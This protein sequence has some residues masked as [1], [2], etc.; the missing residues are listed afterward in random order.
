M[1]FHHTRSIVSMIGYGDIV[2]RTEPGKIATL[3]Y[4][5]FG[6]PVYIL[7]FMS[8]GKVFASVL[9]WVYTKAY[10]WNVRRKW[11][12]SVDYDSMASDAELDEAYLDEL[13]QQ[14]R[15]YKL[16]RY[17]YMRS[18]FL[19]TFPVGFHVRKSLLGCTV[20]SN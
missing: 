14:V 4:A 17:V 7:Y 16:K 10:R 15:I 5:S 3:V 12:Q 18:Q 6:I 2:P 9:K 13:E 19:F 1:S 20:R 8:M 11:K